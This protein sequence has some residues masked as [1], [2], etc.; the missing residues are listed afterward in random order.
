MHPVAALLYGIFGV[1]LPALRRPGRRS[2]SNHYLRPNLSFRRFVKQ[3]NRRNLEYVVLD[4]RPVGREVLVTDRDLDKLQDLITHSPTGERVQIYTPSARPGTAYFSPLAEPRPLNRIAI[5]PAR[6]AHGILERAERSIGGIRVPSVADA[7]FARAYRAAYLEAV[8]CDWTDPSS[9]CSSCQGY[10]LELRALA[11]GAQVALPDQFTLA[12]LDELLAE[13]GWRPPA[14]LLEKAAEWAPWLRARFPELHGPRSEPPGLAIFFI[15]ERAQAAGLKAPIVATLKAH[16]LDPLLVLDLD[17]SQRSLVADGVR[18]GNWGMGPWKV[19]GGRPAC[20]VV[21]L[22]VDP[23]P[24]GPNAAPQRWQLD[25]QRVLKAKMAVRNMITVNLPRN[26]QYNGLHSTDHADQA[27]RVIR[28]VIPEQ[29][30]VLRAK[31]DEARSKIGFVA[32]ERAPRK[33]RIKKGASKLC[34][35]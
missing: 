27:W 1:P 15:R 2:V 26:E 4:D 35:Q 10:H 28:L 9:L 8:C 12:T 29:E 34:V 30:A 3:L 6:L 20:L 14:D 19:D 18:G 21:T 16:G 25:D 11:K 13:K 22:D 5:Y 33:K 24:P 23:I 31:I 32:R 17:E 7:F